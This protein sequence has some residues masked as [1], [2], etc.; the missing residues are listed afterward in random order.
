MCCRAQE[1]S[2]MG[3]V[4]IG[5]DGMW[6]VPS[7]LPIVRVSMGR[8]VRIDVGPWAEIVFPGWEGVWLEESIVVIEG[9]ILW[10][11]RVSDW[12]W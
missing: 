3:S 9:D 7:R 4:K 6:I 8:E 12:R 11:L 2:D 5:M 10:R 1:R